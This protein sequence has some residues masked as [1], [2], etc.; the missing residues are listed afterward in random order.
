MERKQSH[1]EDFSFNMCGERNHSDGEIRSALFCR[2]RQQASVPGF[3][4]S[5]HSLL[6]VYSTTALAERRGDPQSQPRVI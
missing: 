4:P 2:M 6:R 1:E 3:L 5:L